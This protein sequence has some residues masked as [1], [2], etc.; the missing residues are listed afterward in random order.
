[1]LAVVDT[2]VWVSAFLTPE[3]TAAAVLDAFRA[4]R[5]IP[6]Y[7]EAIE[8]E[9]RNVLIRPRF[10]IETGLIDEFLA[11]IRA[12]GMPGKLVPPF[13]PDLPDPADA[14]FI[15]LAQTFCCPIVTGNIR[16]F[17]PHAG[18]EVLSPRQCLERILG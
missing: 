18:I 2:N 9:Y 8:S 13:P 16:H 12:C 3:G 15:V 7:C 11:L 6:V 10:Q 1:M 5:L 17:P 4:G 14:P